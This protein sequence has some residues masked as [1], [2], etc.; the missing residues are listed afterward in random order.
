MRTQRRQ[1]AVLLKGAATTPTLPS[2]VVSFGLQ[3]ANM[4]S[5]AQVEPEVFCYLSAPVKGPGVDVALPLDDP[6]RVTQVSLESYL[7]SGELLPADTEICFF[8]TG[9]RPNEMGAACRVPAGIGRVSLALLAKHVHNSIELVVPLLVPSDG[10]RETGRLKLS[11]T[12]KQVQIA[13]SIRWSSDPAAAAIAAIARIGAAQQQNQKEEPE[14]RTPVEQEMVDYIEDI[15]RTG[16]AM[17]NRWAETSN[18]RIPIYYG[19]F[20]M[21]KI[22]APLPAAAYF[23]CQV[24]ESNLRFWTEALDDV[25]KRKG[26]VTHDLDRMTLQEQ[27]DVMVT[28]N[29]RLTWALDY[30]ADINDGNRRAVKAAAGFIG[31]LQSL[32]SILCSS[33]GAGATVARPYNVALVD[34]GENFNEAGRCG[35]G[36]C[37]DVSRFTGAQVFPAFLAADFTG[38]RHLKRL[39]EIGHQYVVMMSLDSVMGASV[40]DGK[41]KM[42]AHLKS[43]FFPAK[44]LKSRMDKAAGD[45]KPAKVGGRYGAIGEAVA[46]QRDLPWKPFAPWADELEVLIA[47]GTGPYEPRDMAVDHL[48][49]T[50]VAVGQAV[51]TMDQIMKHPL[52]HVKGQDSGFFLGSMEGF[53]SYFFELGANV[54]GF[55]IGETRPGSLT[56]TRGVSFADLVNKSDNISVLAHPP[57]SDAVMAHVK[58][59]LRIAVP[60][61][62]L[63][64]TEAGMAAQ[65][66]N[67][68]KLDEL[69]AFATKLGRSISQASGDPAPYFVREHQLT[70]KAMNA[71]KDEIQRSQSIAGLSYVVEHVTDWCHL[72]RTGVFVK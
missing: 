53:T 11:T 12:T 9:K 20:G 13:S 55:W 5:Q 69:A 25:L 72:Y 65:P 10:N 8:A 19:D 54:G 67:C 34:N 59:S 17:P 43:N 50:R 33:H 51:P 39:Q 46:G 48:H 47:E 30:I 16:M 1:P 60:P 70:D 29:C 42:G 35:C 68:A 4:Q 36:D 21:T 64:L 40:G 63:I 22:S 49:N 58:H 31:K 23:I 32:C 14:K 56:M 41:R 71:I 66:K 7:P 26:L 57:L 3:Y 61:R 52:V 15:M 62:P 38:H 28:I 27:A 24:P 2:I 44:W 6:Q 45:L 18:V 37:E